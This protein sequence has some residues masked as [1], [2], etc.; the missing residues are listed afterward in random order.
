MS[1]TPV[2]GT[3]RP[4]VFYGWWIVLATL[5]MYAYL[6]GAIYWSF[7]FLISPIRE[8]MG[9]SVGAISLAYLVQGAV[10]ALAAPLVGVLFDRLGPK[11]VSGGGILVGGL[12][13]IWMSQVDAV[14]QFAL[15]YAVAGLA[16]I[17]AFGAGV[18]AVANWFVRRR[19]LA[20]GLQSLG[21]AIA[22][23]M[24]PLVAFLVD[25]MG[26]RSALALLGIGTW[27]L[28]LPLVLVL[29]RRP[30]DYGQAPDGEASAPA[31][32]AVSS[33]EGATVRQALG[34]A[35]FWLLALAFLMGFWAIGGIQVHLSPYLEGVNISREVAATVMAVLSVATVL[36][37]V[38]FGW[39][40]DRA[41]MRWLLAAALVLQ[42]MGVVL[43]GLVDASR[44]WLLVAFLLTF[45]PALGGIMVLQPAIQGLYFGRRA[46][47]ALA[48]LFYGLNSLSWSAAPYLMGL[49]YDALGGYRPGLFLFAA[50]SAAGAPALLAL[51]RPPTPVVPST[52]LS[53]APAAT[54]S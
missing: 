47:G 36:G 17:S 49:L 41:D 15:A 24:A 6:A 46:F 3:R 54:R 20:L 33:A 1:Q 23:A 14:W 38:L 53:T 44:P 34:R 18:P 43:F 50:F 13:L 21:I 5:A 7:S 48:G 28:T 30:E 37:R 29:R 12:G 10:G 52:A 39:L 19:G 9:W 22:G 16:P 45:S 42:A 32:V 27:V 25:S 11:V 2:S 4:R 8:E 35:P 51:R 40:A 26:W 31:G